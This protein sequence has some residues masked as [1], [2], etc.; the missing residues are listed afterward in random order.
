[1]ERERHA[2]FLTYRPHLQ[3]IA[4]KALSCNVRNGWKADIGLMR[5]CPISASRNREVLLVL[6]CKI[7]SVRE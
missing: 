6:E 3:S 4:A 2:R 7:E 5:T 1:M